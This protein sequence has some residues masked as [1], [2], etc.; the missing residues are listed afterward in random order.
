M[1]SDKLIEIHNHS[2][3]VNCFPSCPLYGFAGNNN[4]TATTT[5]S[6]SSTTT[7]HGGVTGQVISLVSVKDQK[8]KRMVAK[9]RQFIAQHSDIFFTMDNAKSLMLF[10]PALKSTNH[11]PVRVEVSPKFVTFCM[12]LAIGSWKEANN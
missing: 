4:T 8:H 12:L 7:T 6:T 9:L 2:D 1:E 5:G 11:Y 10:L 3:L